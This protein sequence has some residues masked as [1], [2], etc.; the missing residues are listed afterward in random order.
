MLRVAL[1][2]ALPLAWALPA[3]P[4]VFRSGID[5]VHVVVTVLDRRGT[6]VKGLRAED[7]AVYEDGV[8]QEIRYFATGEDR[9]PPPLHLGLLFDTSGSM[10]EDVHLS[11][12]AAVKFLNAATRAVDVTLVDFAT[13]VRVARYGPR[14]FPRLIERI[15][16]R[17]PEGYTALYDAIGVYL[18]GAADQE[19]EKVLVI[20]TDGGDT[21]SAMSFSECLSL[22]RLSD[23]TVYAI[24]FLQHQPSS[25]RTAQELYL[26][27]IAAATGGEA[28][29]PLSADD[30]DGMYGKIL[31][32]L[33]A[34]YSLGYLSTNTRTDG[35]WRRLEVR[36]TRPGLKGVRVR[37]RPGYYGP[38]KPPAHP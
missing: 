34:R 25:V 28:Y 23:V 38:A 32:E 31:D 5:L 13:E 33:A 8:R 16:A 24:G 4:Q 19:G 15:R 17:R 22:L 18:D 36:L 7:F 29:F 11:R 27:Q 2:C 10:T 26:R 37:T 35:A 14:D 30:L 20:Y 3:G 1:A 21:T 9:E 6:P 12:T